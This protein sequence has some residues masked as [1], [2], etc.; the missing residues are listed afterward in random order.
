VELEVPR[1][2]QSA[3]RQ[4]SGKVIWVQRP[5][6]TRE[7]FHIAVDFEVPG[8]VWGIPSPPGDWFPVPGDLQPSS[9][10]S[11]EPPARPNKRSREAIEQ[12]D[13]TASWDESEIASVSQAANK[14]KAQATTEET[15]TMNVE[16]VSGDT[17]VDAEICVVIENTVK[18]AVARLAKSI[19]DEAREERIAAAA[20][21][22]AK[23]QQAV[24]AAVA[25]L[26][27]PQRKRSKKRN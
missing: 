17:R 10:E 5:R 11:D 9:H 19:A 3:P 1:G 18:A 4:V 8:N 13:A 22:D 20:Q 12:Q 23:V 27:S 25:K 6:N 26:P 2:R 16:I 15:D 21:L 7:V 24:E 14:I